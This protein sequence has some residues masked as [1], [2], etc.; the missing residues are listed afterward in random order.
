MKDYRNIQA[1]QKAHELTLQ[2]YKATES[3]PQKELYGLISQ[4]RRAAV[5]IPANIA[6]GY[7][8]TTDLEIARFMDISL[9]SA[10]EVEYLLLLSADLKYCSKQAA[11]E[12]SHK[13]VEIR[14]MLSSFTKTIRNSPSKAGSR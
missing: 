12:L 8:R 9:G 6:E 14:K 10:N 3:F 1:W 11:D 4:L 7:G 2:I 13:L 5:S